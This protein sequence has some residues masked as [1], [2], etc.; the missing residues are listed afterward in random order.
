MTKRKKIGV[1]YIIVAV[2]LCLFLFWFQANYYVNI[3][4]SDSMKPEFEKGDITIVEKDLGI[5]EVEEGDIIAYDQK[6]SD[7]KDVIH[8]VIEKRNNKIITQG[9]NEKLKDQTF[10]HYGDRCLE[11]LK[12]SDIKGK[13]VHIINI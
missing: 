8:R 3:T 4:P 11:P 2:V 1:I 5:Q 12:E 6:C 9:D 10:D 7:E 13:V